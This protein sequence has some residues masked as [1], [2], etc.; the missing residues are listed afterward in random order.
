MGLASD[1]SVGVTCESLLGNFVDTEIDAGLA[2][3][4]DVAVVTCVYT[5][6]VCVGG[7]ATSEW[8]L[9]DLVWPAVFMSTCAVLTCDTGVETPGFAAYAVMPLVDG[10]DWATVD[11]NVIGHGSIPGSYSCTELCV[12]CAV[13]MAYVGNT[14]ANCN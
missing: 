14:H 5:D 2:T 12:E 10:S 4:V 9:F 13:G 11:A 3:D 6:V 8:F 1:T 7:W